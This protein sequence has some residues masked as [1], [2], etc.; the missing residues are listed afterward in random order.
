MREKYCKL[1][2]R[3]R[4]KNGISVIEIKGYFRILEQ[5]KVLKIEIHK[6]KIL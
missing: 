1:V 4:G 6:N 5:K 2:H 3:R